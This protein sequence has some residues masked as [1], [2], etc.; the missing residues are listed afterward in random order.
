MALHR[1]H[2]GVHPGCRS[3]GGGMVEKVVFAHLVERF[4]AEI[5]PERLKMCTFAREMTLLRNATRVAQCYS[6]RSRLT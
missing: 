2:R 5:A 1:H 6:R 3:F 4:L